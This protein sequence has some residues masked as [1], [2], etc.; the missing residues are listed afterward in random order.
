MRQ[1]LENSD[2]PFDLYIHGSPEHVCCWMRSIG[3]NPDLADRVL[4]IP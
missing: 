1:H 3:M 4:S 2:E